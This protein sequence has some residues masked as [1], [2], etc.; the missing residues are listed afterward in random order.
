LPLDAELSLRCDDAM[1]SSYVAAAEPASIGLLDE[2]RLAAA[3]NEAT[4]LTPGARACVVLRSHGRTVAARIGGADEPA[5]IGCIAKLLTAT[6][7][8]AAVQTGRLSFDADLG[9]VLG[10]T[11]GALR[12]ITLRHLLE[13]T[14]GLDDS[15]LDE[16]R[17][18]GGFLDASEFLERAALLPRFAP[19]GACYS[20][21]HLGAWLAALVLERVQA[22]RF[23]ELARVWLEESLGVPVTVPMAACPALGGGIALDA[24]ALAR[25]AAHA[26]AGPERWPSGEVEGT[27]GAVTP[28]PGWNPLERGVFLGWKHSGRTWFGHQSA[29]PHAS[30]YVRAQPATG[31]AIAVLARTHSAAVIAAKVFG[32]AFPELFA[33][34][35]P[36]GSGVGGDDS[37]WVGRYAQAGLEVR[38]DRGAGGLLLGAYARRSDTP[39]IH[40][41]LTAAGAVRLATP[42]NDRVP[43]VELV[44][45]GPERAR[46][47]WNGRGLLR[48]VRL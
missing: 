40:A 45:A 21:G 4:Q 3:L 19:T 27:Y 34:R 7:V 11:A 26:V 17:R 48:P 29:W 14:H 25:L 1:R 46:W 33:L 10:A 41:R 9:A 6:L 13:H 8:R 5:P 39:P 35:P 38:I 2:E 30:A 44:A 16:P 12:R 28:L 15:V 20:Y 23:A 43:F 37:A 24:V 42:A 36:P 31:L 18:A 32:R 22:R 47:L